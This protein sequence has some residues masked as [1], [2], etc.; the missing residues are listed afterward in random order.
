MNYQVSGL[1]FDPTTDQTY[2]VHVSETFNTFTL[3]SLDPANGD[4]VGIG[5]V[6][7][8]LRS[9]DF[10]S[11]G[12]AWA[13][14]ATSSAPEQLHEL[15]KSTGASI[16]QI[17]LDNGFDYES[18]AIPNT[19]PPNEPPVFDQ[20]LLDRTDAEG[21]LVIIAASATDPNPGDNLTYSATELPEG[22]TIDSAN[23]TLTGALGP[24]SA[25]VYSITITVT[26]DGTPNLQD[27]DI[28]DWTVAPG[29]VTYLVANSGGANGGNDLLT[30]VD[31]T[32]SNPTT[33]E[34]SIGTGTGTW[35]I[36]SIAL[37]PGTN[38]LFAV[39][40]DQLGIIDVTTGV[41]A[42]RPSIAG[43]GSGPAGLIAFDDIEGLSF[44]PF[45]GGLY[46]THRRG[47]WQE[48]LL[49]QI[50]PVSGAHIPGVF[51]GDDYLLIGAQGGYYHSADI[52]FDPTNG[53]LYLV[54]W[55]FSGDWS[56]ATLDPATGATV[57]LGVTPDDVASLAFDETGRLYTSTDTAGTERIYELSKS[58]GSSLGVIDIDNGE[59]YEALAIAFP[60]DPNRPPVFDQ[61]LLDRTDPE[62]STISLSAAATDPD[63]HDVGYSA[64]GLP[65]G[66]AI[67]PNSG[68]ISGTI[69]FAATGS[70][71]VEITATDDGIPN[72]S[73]V[74]TFTWTVSESNRPPV[75][76]QDLLDRIDAEGAPISLSAAATDPDSGDIVTYGATGLPPGLSID[77]GSGLISGT[78]DYNAAAGSPYAVTITATDNGTPP[79]S[80]VP[81]TFTWTVNNTNRPPVI[82]NPGPQTTPELAPFSIVITA[83]DPDGTT[84]SFT[85]SGTLPA[86]AVLTDN[87]DGTATIAG[88][89][90]GGD[91]GTTTVTVTASDGS[92]ADDAVFDLTVS[93]TNQPPTITNPGNQI[94]AEATPFSLLITASDP[95][96]TTVGFSDGGTLPGWATLTDNG[97]DTATISG[98]P[99]YTDAGTTTVTIT[100]WDGSLTDD[101][102]FDITINNTN[103]APIVDPIVDQTVAENDPFTL[104]VTA[105]DA[106]GTIPSL[107]AAGLP[108]WATFVDNGD[109]TGTISGTPGYTDAGIS[110][111]TISADDGT[112]TGNETFDLTVTNTNRPPV[113]NPVGDQLAAEGVALV[114]VVVSASDPDGTIPSLAATGL[115]GW[116][117]FVD[118]GDG[119][120][121]ITGTPGYTDAGISTVTIEAED[122]GVPNLS[123]S[124]PFQ[125]T[126]TNTNRP[127]VVDPI[128]DQTV[129]ENDPFTLTVTASDPD[130]TIPSLAATGLPG[131]AS[132]VDNGDG[133]GTISGTPGY[134]DA[135]IST[136]TVTAHDGSLTDDETFDLT[137]TNT[138]RPP[139]ITSPGPQTTPEL[140]PFTLLVV[141]TDPDG[142]IPTLADGGTLPGWAT[143]TDNGDGTGTISGTPGASDSGTTTVTITAD[144]GGVPNLTDDVVF[145][146]TVTNTNRPPTITNPG[147]Q[148]GAEGSSFSVLLTATDPDGTTVAF[149]D[150]GTLPGWA[151]LTD[152]GDDTATITGTPGYTDAATTTVTI[153]VTD[154]GLIDTA[155]FSIVI[156]D[157]DRPP[158]I[159]PIADQVVAENDPFTL[160]ATASDPD[161]TTPSLSASGLPGWATFVDNGDGTGTVTGTPGYTDAATTTVTITASA[162]GLSHDE[163]FIITVTDTNRRPVLGL[164]PDH[165]VPEETTITFTATASDLDGDNLLFS[166]SGP[167]G[168][169]IDPTSGDFVWTPGEAD[170]FG[171]YLVTVTVTDSGHPAKAHSKS[172][173]ITVTEVNRAPTVD[174]VPDQVSGEFGDVDLTIAASDPDLPANT[175]S[176]HASGLP[177]GLAIDDDTGHISGTL[178]AGSVGVY[179]VTVT[180]SDGASPSLSGSASFVWTVTD[181]NRPPTLDV[182]SSISGAE[183]TEISFTARATDPDGDDVMF[184][185]SG[186]PAGATIDAASGVVTWIPTEA[187]GP[188]TYRLTV[189]ATDAGSPQLAARRIVTISVFETN[190]PPTIE[191]LSSQI[192]EAAT[193]VEIQVAGSD[194]D[195]PSNML[196]FS[197]EGLPQ[198]LRIDRVTGMI[199][200]TI[201]QSATGFHVVAIT[202]ADD[203]IPSLQASTNLTW[204]V[205]ASA[206][207][208]DP[209]SAPIISPVA[210]QFDSEGETV[211]LSI[212]ASDEQPLSYS[213]TGLPTGL[214]IDPATGVIGGRL[215]VNTAGS[216][217]V[218]VT[219]TDSG[220]PQLQAT[221]E[222]NWI[223]ADPVAA[224]DKELIIEAIDD[225]EQPSVGQGEETPRIRRT[226][227]VMGGV[228]SATT[229]AL[230]LPLTLLIVLLLGFTTIGRIGLYPLLWRGDRHAG[231]ISFFDEEMHFG[232]IDPD[233]GGEA[234]FVH[235]HAFPRRQ[236]AGLNAGMRVRYRLLASDQRANAWGATVESDDG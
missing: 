92:L 202:V 115:P 78:I 51:G 7:D 101:A 57:T 138:N 169:S 1:A 114:P 88:T 166:I 183:E 158:T 67:D 131:W 73:A 17:D 150:G 44:D 170:G 121:T 112:D 89:P 225:F 157:T 125:L 194:P 5:T 15:D 107:S 22:V 143:L 220:T 56:L 64:V 168:A 147:D 149:S 139:T 28:F 14:T 72:L 103:R 68:L 204:M 97:D 100:A 191:P 180:V 20:D 60:V 192:S 82:V 23:G 219:V 85:D 4:T 235:A 108:G 197:A 146:L 203:G 223:V 176:F 174:P 84:P 231:T 50:D 177:P 70:Y 41:F 188:G 99:G 62:G 6:P 162:G 32:D 59:S 120:G 45:S 148:G 167:P 102:V 154:G 87:L 38:T 93:N 40:D 90:G 233:A 63:G 161:G 126:V 195:L 216:H 205:T 76:D 215:A 104:T 11:D 144:D 109:G 234:I 19:P 134:T 217:P 184:S 122:G 173:T 116:A 83:S 69:G 136:A 155:T 65:P 236:R 221:V 55:D 21:T 179:P 206:L 80:A 2:V 200:G 187:Q 8:D 75:F 141:A 159:E 52:A 190:L 10:D 163:S 54:H 61:N 48:D 49:F 208:D 130:G 142:E 29:D 185:L 153:T 46:G 58:D 230:S 86:W 164:I 135:G 33:N 118:N 37:Q 91:S 199:T 129:A 209:N 128:V 140:A 213:A 43:A 35:N 222:F 182:A 106:D 133:T 232:L 105:S 198:G 25:G 214:A 152:N 127:P 111:V 189:Y 53:E 30:A 165:T 186:E 81:D 226:L 193:T 178:P 34:V 211:T 156:S 160:V 210:T 132:F 94:G 123:D 201:E 36:E 13:T 113:V 3:S 77:P 151:T 71:A 24:N 119:T 18:L 26:D 31:L 12:R 42:P 207:Q 74:D 181:T 212:L 137:V 171:V 145:D 110:T 47:N 224:E 95:D 9:L 66:L 227:V 228:A 16:A 175:L 79:E 39:E 124:T 96:G 229:E 27:T 98:T 172:V 196:S 218:T 117:S